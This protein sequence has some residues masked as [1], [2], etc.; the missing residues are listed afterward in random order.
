MLEGSGEKRKV[1]DH[2]IAR[3]LAASN[4]NILHP[5][6]TQV[7]TLPEWALQFRPY[8]GTVDTPESLLY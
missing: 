1:S 6:E 2:V 5:M 3:E 7:R 4:G 8:S